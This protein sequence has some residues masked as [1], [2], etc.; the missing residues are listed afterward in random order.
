MMLRLLINSETSQKRIARSSSW[1]IYYIIHIIIIQYYV[2]I[3]RSSSWAIYCIIVT[4]HN[5]SILRL[6]GGGWIKRA[7]RV[8]RPYYHSVITRTISTRTIFWYKMDKTAMIFTDRLLT[9]Q[10]QCRNRYE[11]RELFFRFLWMLNLMKTV[12]TW[13]NSGKITAISQTGNFITFCPKADGD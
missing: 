10:L 7:L 5:H 13:D 4:N 2:W 9:M 8:M 11:K 6:N 12:L 3:A 1:A